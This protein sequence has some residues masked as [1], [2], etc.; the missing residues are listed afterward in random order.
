MS[1]CSVSLI[2]NATIIEKEEKSYRAY[3]VH[4]I[5]AGIN[6]Y[7]DPET[8]FLP[9]EAPLSAMTKYLKKQDMI[10]TERE[11]Y[12]ADGIYRYQTIEFCIN[13][14]SGPFNNKLRS[15]YQFDFHKA[16]YGC[17]S[18]MWDIVQ[19]F[20]LATFTTLEELDIYFLHC[21]SNVGPF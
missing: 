11:V 3:F 7:L 19:N 8:T 13:E 12:K 9:A 4:S 20:Y 6:N 14:I 2:N 15:K 10:H 1:F 17:M 21:K 16:M 5:C 18:I